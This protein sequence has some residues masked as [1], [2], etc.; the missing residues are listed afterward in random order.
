MKKFLA[1][2][3]AT[4]MLL[5]MLAACN[6][7][8]QVE[9]PDEP[10]EPSQGDVTEMPEEPKDPAIEEPVPVPEYK[11]YEV[12][13]ENTL[14]SKNE[15]IS[16]NAAENILYVTSLSTSANKEN[17]LAENSKFSLP[18]YIK[19][20]KKKTE[21]NWEYVSALKYENKEVNGVLTNGLVYKFHE[22]T[23][24]LDLRVYCVVRP[25]L[26]GPFEFY[27]EVDNLN[28][29]EIRIYLEG[30]FASLS[31]KILDHAATD[32][33]RIASEG[34]IAEGHVQNADALNNPNYNNGVMYEGTGIEVFN[35]SNAKLISSE[36]PDFQSNGGD[37]TAQFIDRENDGIFYALAWTTGRVWSKVEKD[38]YI[39][40]K[41]SLD[42]D[43]GKFETLIQPGDTFI[44][45]SVYVL[46]YEG[47]IDD[48]SNIFKAWFFDC[49]VV[50]TLRDDPALPYVQIDIQMSPEDAKAAGIDSMKRE[51]G[52]WSGIG[53]N[54][55][56][57]LPYEGS[58][59]LMAD[60]IDTPNYTHEDMKNYGAKLD[61]LGLN[62][63]MYILL[64]ET[65]DENG[66]PT[67]QYG[68]LN[69]VT[70]PEW[71]SNQRHPFCRLADLGNVE[72][73][74]YLKTTLEKFF[75]NNNVD[76]W[77]TD[78]EPIAVYSDQKNRHDANGSDVSYWC[79]VGF[80]EIVNHLYD[81]VEGF[82]F[83]S[84]N[85][86][87]GDKNLYIAELTT[88]FNCDDTANYL[89][90][91]TS[92]YDSSYIIHPA[93]LEI[94]CNTETFNPNCKQYFFPVVP[95]PEVAAEDTYDF[96]DAMMDMGF[97]STIIGIPM[98][99]PWTG[100]VP[101]EYYNEYAHMYKERVKPLVRDGE[102]YHIL[103]RPD[104]V[105][106]DGIMYADPDSANEI[107]GVVFLFKPS[108][109][110]ENVKNIVFD[111]LDESTVYQ[112]TFEDR[113]EQNCTATGAD[114]MTNG[115][116]VEIKYVGSEM[117][118]ITEAK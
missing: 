10:D 60:G 72:C 19:I 90:L 96:T 91:R 63:A 7:E 117:I 1:I 44:I 27:M 16:L 111:G 116:D 110:V 77:R 15:E 75:K 106:W 100:I 53:F 101:A 11:E 76:Q 107:K 87:G 99:A 52:W 40:T 84:C 23:Q 104:G 78:F 26:S 32:V 9:I 88:F 105:N 37:Y 102:L 74:E 29:S 89:S 103:P 2:L 20:D 21:L 13:A 80:A 64:H 86:G 50:P 39:E 49:K 93:Q 47:D 59:T 51:Y 109:D 92:F 83:E 31:T 73:V 36:R 98:W 18:K 8:Q 6:N 3:L 65:V 69:A 58:W 66:N 112:L 56:R 118:W 67:D 68:E 33:I 61:E 25:E 43:E 54:A 24:N 108:A 38:G 34:F 94:P 45:P 14:T 85:S 62:Y 70:H 46:P 71:F 22:A 114:L 113:P 48:G 115:I 12:S 97:R 82:K 4:S 28:E 30:G 79:T 95:K 35:L 81:T 42:N 17:K 57:P 5:T 55:E 41:A